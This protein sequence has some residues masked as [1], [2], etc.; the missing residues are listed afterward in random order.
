MGRAIERA[1]QRE[2]TA[3]AW[4]R[5]STGATGTLGRRRLARAIASLGHAQQQLKRAHK[6]ITQ[7]DL[8]VTIETHLRQLARLLALTRDQLRS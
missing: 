3:V 5:R 6:L 2:T 1:A 7:P 8:A 4:L